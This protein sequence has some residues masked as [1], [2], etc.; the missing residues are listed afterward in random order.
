V[1]TDREVFAKFRLSIDNGF[2]NEFSYVH[3]RRWGAMELWEGGRYRS[4][5]PKHAGTMCIEVWLNW[6]LVGTYKSY[7]EARGVVRRL[8]QQSPVPLHD[9]AHY[10][11]L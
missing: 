5:P 6:A 7:D 4:A 9:L 2:R 3:Y 10:V 8:L 11:T 1:T